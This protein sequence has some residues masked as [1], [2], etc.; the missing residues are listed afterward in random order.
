MVDKDIQIKTFKCDGDDYY[1]S[2]INK[3][4][5]AKKEEIRIIDKKEVG[6]RNYMSIIFYYKKINKK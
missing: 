6:T 5:S 3:W 2:I 4:L 1:D